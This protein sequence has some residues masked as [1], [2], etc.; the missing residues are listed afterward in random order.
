MPPEPTLGIIALCC[1][2]CLVASTFVGFSGFGFAL[3]AVPIL[4][5]ALDLKFVV[6]LELLIATFCVVV[7]SL[8][9]FRFF[10][11]PMVFILFIGMLT[12]VV[13]GA[14]VLANFETA[15]LKKILGIVVMFF[16][17]HMVSQTFQKESDRIVGRSLGI[18]GVPIAFFVG[19]LSGLAG[20]LF[21]TSGPPL[22]IYVDYFAEDKSAFRGQILVLFFLQNVFRI[23][24][25]LRNSLMTVDVGKF[26]LWMIP[27]A[28]LGLLVGSKLHHHVSE[29]VFRRAVACM[30]FVS[31]ILLLIR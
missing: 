12:G 11:N 8:N 26:A 20:G 3:I 24:L 7:L 9:K 29:K 5:L 25:Y 19:I 14:H 27:S 23:M 2:V 10:K 30:L 17:A 22:V 21:G 13:A 4:S 18:L 16:A 31:S 15:I 6:P 28:C 1:I